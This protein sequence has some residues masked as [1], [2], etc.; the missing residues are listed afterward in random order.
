VFWEQSSEFIPDNLF[1]TIGEIRKWAYQEGLIWEPDSQFVTPEREQNLCKIFQPEDG[2]LIAVHI[3]QDS[4]GRLD[5]LEYPYVPVRTLI[6]K[7]MQIDIVYWQIRLGEV[8]FGFWYEDIEAE[9]LCSISTAKRVIRKFSELFEQISSEY[10]AKRLNNGTLEI[11]VNGAVQAK[12]FKEGRYFDVE[13]KVM[14]SGEDSG[15]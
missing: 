4:S 1:P 12:F 14:Y 6:K 3:Y 15:S 10:D 5:Y 13:L 2:L 9:E 8:R 11:E 7:E